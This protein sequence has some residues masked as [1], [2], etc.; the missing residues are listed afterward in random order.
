MDTENLIEQVK[1]N[2]NISDA[3]SWGYYSICGLLLRV[4]ELYKHEK[5]LMPWEMIPSDDISM[6]L[7]ER[8]KL[9]KEFENKDFCP[10]E[11]NGRSFGVFEVEKINEILNEKGL[12]YGGGY[13]IYGKPTFFLANLKCRKELY[14]YNVYY[15]DKE[16]CRD[17]STSTAMLQGICIFLR[18]EQ[19]IHA[20]W[21]RVHEMKARKFSYLPDSMLSFWFTEKELAEPSDLYKKIFTI[22]DDI[23]DIFI[24][25]EIAEA[26]EDRYSLQWQDI[27]GRDR[28][29][30][31]HLRGLKDII[32]DTS[33]YGPLKMIVNRKDKNLLVFYTI[34]SDNIR[35][36]L[37]PDITESLQAFLKSD[38]WEMLEKI[39]VWSY[40]ATDSVMER[41]SEMIKNNNDSSSIKLLIK[42]HIENIK[43]GSNTS[44][45]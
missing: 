28:W 6:W 19:L 12:I 14:D 37:S 16:L 41:I 40:K 4:R 10:I 44:G 5:G 32:A 36:S 18:K 25:H 42:D 7:E 21:E 33:D 39:R 2:C 43:K 31:L 13:G 35:K 23:S 22:A 15:V 29:L 8:E 3:R 38:D 1:Y 26:I 27:I 30:E 20:L 34:F 11:I 24:Y 45:N 17:L 9:W